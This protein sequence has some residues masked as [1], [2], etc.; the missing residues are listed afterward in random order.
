MER[1]QGFV[2][3]VNLSR[4]EFHAVDTAKRLL[5]SNGFIEVSEKNAWKLEKGGRYFYTRNQSSL[6]A[7]A[8]GGQFV[9]GNGFNIVAAHTDSPNLKLKPNTNIQKHGFM[10][11]GVSM[12]GGGIWHTWF[13]RDLTLAGRVIVKTENGYDS[14]LVFINQPI[15]RIPS[16]AIH[17]DR[18]VNEDFKFNHEDNF[19]PILGT[20]VKSQLEQ[21]D[22]KSPNSSLLLNLLAKKLEINVDDIINFDLD[23]CDY[24][25]SVIGGINNEFVFSPR[26]DNLVSSYC[27]VMALIETCDTLDKETNIRAIVLYDNEEV[28]S[29]SYNGACSTILKD[30]IFR[31]TEAFFLDE[32]VKE[33]ESLFAR[34]LR[35]SFLI[36][37]DMAH[38]LHPNYSSKHEDKHRPKIHEG[39]VIKVNANLRYATTSESAFFIQELAKI[40]NIPLQKFVV[41]NDS[42]CGSTIGPIVSS[43]LGIRTIDI[44]APQL[45]MH[46]IREMCGVDDIGHY[47]NMMKAFFN[48][49]SELD[50]KF[51]LTL[52]DKD[53]KIEETH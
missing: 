42:P 9:P 48:Q 25:D 2:D 23:I 40:N 47:C 50:T 34:A 51:Q 41:R 5:H 12:Y 36:S 32:N 28:G 13:D 20:I 11:L 4:S 10:Q 15:L 22:D 31:A 53:F 43:Q 27:S 52:W 38:A 17:L 3:F 21:N 29:T 16:L 26:I 46:S 39:V 14:R 18:T 44:G 35:N 37:A 24:Q 7:F 8:I 49:F 6:V 19:V 30:C 1:A 33:A 45:A